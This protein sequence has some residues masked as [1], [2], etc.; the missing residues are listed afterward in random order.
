MNSELQSVCS[1]LLQI[2]EMKNLR[3]KNRT[4]QIDIDCLSKEIDLLQ[5][6][7][8]HWLLCLLYNS[9]C[10]TNVMNRFLVNVW[11]IVCKTGNYWAKQGS[12]SL[13]PCCLHTVLLA[14]T[15]SC[16]ASCCCWVATDLRPPQYDCHRLP[17]AKQ[18]PNVNTLFIM[19]F[20]TKSSTT[21]RITWA[22]TD[23]RVYFT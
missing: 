18:L 17:Q 11:H 10:L 22:D 3:C 5:T 9:L 23:V 2:D 6:N 14:T 20:N 19:L 13:L 4:L 21:K 12:S 15:S 1:V 16:I 7:G 8:M